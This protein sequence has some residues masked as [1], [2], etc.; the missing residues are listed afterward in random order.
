MT[1]MTE[2]GDYD[3]MAGLYQADPIEVHWD[4]EASANVTMAEI[5]AE[6]THLKEHFIL[7]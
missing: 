5:A 3:L 6:T 4:E 7:E 1:K 2:R